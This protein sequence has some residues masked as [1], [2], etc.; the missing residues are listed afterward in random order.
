[1]RMFTK[2]LEGEV[3]RWFKE[4]EGDSIEDMVNFQEVFLNK[5][6]KR[7]THYKYLSKLYSLERKDDESVTRF[8]RIFHRF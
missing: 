7:K 6:E 1:M 2:S 8:N 4:L 3:G 5:W